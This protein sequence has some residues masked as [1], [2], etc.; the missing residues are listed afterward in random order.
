MLQKGEIY[1]VPQETGVS[2]STGNAGAIEIMIDGEVL[3]TIGSKGAVR[4]DIL[5]DPENLRGRLKK[6]WIGR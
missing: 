4:R 2:L 5:L 3:G 6:S 1:H